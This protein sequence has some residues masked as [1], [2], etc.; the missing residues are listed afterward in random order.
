MSTPFSRWYSSPLKVSIL[1]PLIYSI[2]T[3]LDVEMQITN[4]LHQEIYIILS[5]P[6]LVRDTDNT[7]REVRHQMEDYLGGKLE[8]SVY[9]LDNLNLMSGR[10][11]SI[12]TDYFPDQHEHKNLSLE[13]CIGSRDINQMCQNLVEKRDLLLMGEKWYCWNLVNYS[14]CIQVDGVDY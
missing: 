10:V 13:I 6:P 2:T 7:F 12:Q 14:G 1:N 3:A 5:L 9:N 4:I 8:W 11:V